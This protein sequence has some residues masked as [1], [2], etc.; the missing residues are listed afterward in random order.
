MRSNRYQS[1]NK[2]TWHQ[3]LKK[4]KRNIN[5]TLQWTNYRRC[6]KHSK[7]GVTSKGWHRLRRPTDRRRAWFCV[8]ITARF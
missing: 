1:T 5:H 3:P 6:G 7:S 8:L 2:V 4:V